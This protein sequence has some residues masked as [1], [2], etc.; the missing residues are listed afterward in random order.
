MKY[1][2]TDDKFYVTITGIDGPVGNFREEAEL[3]ARNLSV[4]SSKILLS[5]SSGLDSQVMLHSF[6]SQDLPYE[7]SFLYSPGYNDVEFNQLKILENK[8]G[9]KTIIV[10][11]D[12]VKLRDQ[13]I[14]ESEEYKIE[15][16]A[17]YQK[18]Y[19]S[20]LPAEYDFI[21]SQF[22]CYTFVDSNQKFKFFEGYNSTT[23]SRDRSFKLL[24]RKGKHIFFSE[25]AGTETQRIGY[26]MLSDKIYMAALTADKYFNMPLSGFNRWNAY[27]KP[28]LYAKYWEDE[29]EYFPKL[30]GIENI[31]YLNDIGWW[32]EHGAFIPLFEMLENMRLN[33]T[34][35]YM[36]T[37]H[38]P[39][40]TNHL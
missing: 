10:E 7:C 38:K 1:R 15:R 21:Q 28:L 24:N 5:I 35:E 4:N 19:L 16:N 2:F 20:K 32:H 40:K 12:P 29:L 11:L 14:C 31:K 36:E 18:I 30:T 34:V 13:V 9:F 25:V 8:Y 23:I 17:I 27:I 26:S 39:D 33:R 22:S 3:L 37:Y 6:A